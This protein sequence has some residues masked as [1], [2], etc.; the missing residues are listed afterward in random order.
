[1]NICGVITLERGIL[2][3]FFTLFICVVCGLS[4]PVTKCHGSGVLNMYVKGA[5]CDILDES[6][7]LWG[8]RTMT[9][10]GENRLQ[11]HAALKKDQQVKQKIKVSVYKRAAHEQR[12]QS[13]KNT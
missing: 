12:I 13:D 3:N 2:L 9:A 4:R 10:T 6:F 8:G 5:A 7:L 1:M 11:P